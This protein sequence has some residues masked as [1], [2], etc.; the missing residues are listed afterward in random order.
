MNG[1]CRA[2][3]IIAQADPSHLLDLCLPRYSSG[4]MW[5][6]DLA[7]YIIEYLNG[8]STMTYIGFYKQTNDWQEHRYLYSP[9]EELVWK[10]WV[11]ICFVTEPHIDI[12][13]STFLSMQINVSKS[14][15]SEGVMSLWRPSV[16]CARAAV[17]VI[18]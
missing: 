17:S 12:H 6:L 1:R 7:D 13:V 4:H 11:S 14:E 9:F 2:C 3:C 10:S 8:E 16:A 18:S 5:C 15:E